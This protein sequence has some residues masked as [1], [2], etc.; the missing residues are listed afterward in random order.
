MTEHRIKVLK[1]CIKRHNKKIKDVSEAERYHTL[2]AQKQREVLV[3]LAGE[4]ENYVEEL[5]KL[6]TK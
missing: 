2:Q 3:T 4:V 6:E 1:S 5:I